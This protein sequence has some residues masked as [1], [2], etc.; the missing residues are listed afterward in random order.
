MSDKTDQH[1]QNDPLDHTADPI[2]RMVNV[3]KAFGKLVVLDN[4]SLEF[5][6]GKTTVIV[7]PSGVGKS[8]LLKHIVGLLQPDSGEVYFDEVRIDRL[9]Q[10][11]LTPIRQ[12]IGY[13]FQLG[14]LFDSMTV[15]KNI[16]FPM[17]EQTRWTRE[18]KKQRCHEVLDLVGL[19]GTQNKMPADL[20]GGQ[21]KRVALARAIALEPEVIMYDEPTSG[22]DP[23][24][25]DTINKMISKLKRDLHVTSLVVTHDMNSAFR[26]GDRIMMLHDGKIVEDGTPDQFRKSKHEIVRAFVEGRGL[27]DPDDEQL[28]TTES[29]E[30]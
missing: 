13:L 10:T 14:A 15:E 27:A 22:L 18:K 1:D 2:I 19:D 8:V 7:G 24:R 9:N 20:S 6:R 17:D 11:A 29:R 25:S 21:R 4:V 5:R 23:V 12:R 3:S 16:C 26:I 30:A 28:K